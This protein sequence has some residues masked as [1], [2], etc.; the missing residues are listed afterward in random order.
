MKEYRTCVYVDGFNFYNDIKYLNDEWQKNGE[1]FRVAFPSLQALCAKMLESFPDKHV[2]VKI[3]YFTAMV[4]PTK[5]DPGR[6]KRQTRYNRCL[7]DEGVKIYCGKFLHG[8][9]KRSDVSLAVHLLNDA[10]KDRYDYAVIISNDSDFFEAI[11]IVQKLNKIVD[12]WTLARHP[13]TDLKIA[14]ERHQITVG[15]LNS[16]YAKVV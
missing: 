3:H 13:A 1:N 8:Q 11:K 7:T 5:P 12:V 14:K 16:Q 4:S 9:E 10:W 2:A 15:D 6:Q